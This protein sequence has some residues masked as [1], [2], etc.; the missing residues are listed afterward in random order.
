MAR[1][2]LV[3]TTLA[4][5]CAS[6]V[7]TASA[8]DRASASKKGSLLVYPKVEIRWAPVGPEESYVVTQDTFLTIV[9]DFPADVKV[10]YYF[11]NGDEPLDPVFCCD[12]QELVERGHPGWNWVDCQNIL[13]DDQSIYWSALTGNPHGCQPFTV[14]DPGTPPGRPSLDSIAYPGTRYL[15]GFIVAWA[16]N[17]SGAEIRWNH[18]SGTATLVNYALGTAWEY[19][20]YAFRALTAGPQGAESDGQPGQL[21]M[22]GE[23]YDMN[24]NIL[25]L[26]FF[27]EGS[28]PFYT[29]NGL[30]TD[31]TLMVMEMDLRQDNDGPVTTKAKFDI[32]NSNEVRFSGTERCITCWDQTLLRDYDAP[33]HFLFDNLQ[34]DKGKARIDGLG[35][36]VCP[37]SQDAPLLGVEA[38]FVGYAQIAGQS[39][40]NDRIP[41]QGATASGSSM[42]GQGEDTT[43]FIRNDIIAE[44]EES[45]SGANGGVSLGSLL[46][47]PVR[48]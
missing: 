1:K 23:E 28:D 14:L 15:R 5:L 8:D 43:G 35:S 2:L 32:W 12:P 19:N 20:A 9:N 27:A 21:L 18:L 45:N 31:L 30:N 34:T 10:Q 24:Y 25:V 37:L 40:E 3:G 16:V 4:C 38:K 33:N 47:K 41:L 39:Y 22:N 29:Y 7:S 6:F 42:V 48:K 11:V 13:T 46:A 26:D 17:D 44:P 36:A